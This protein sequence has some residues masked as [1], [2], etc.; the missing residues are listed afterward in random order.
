MSEYEMSLKSENQDLD[1]CL[2]NFEFAMPSLEGYN[3]EHDACL[4]KF[5]IEATMEKYYLLYL[6]YLVNIN[7]QVGCGL[8]LARSFSS[9]ITLSSPHNLNIISFSNHE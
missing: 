1:K 9:A 4:K 6:T 3:Q 5:E 7:F 8:S 2:K